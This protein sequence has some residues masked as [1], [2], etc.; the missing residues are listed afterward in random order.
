MTH[1]KICGLR[2]PEH[3]IAAV[4]AGADMLGFIFYP[5]A[6]RYVDPSLA[7][8]I[9]DAV[10]RRAQ[11]VGVFVNETPERIAEVAD[12]VGLDLVQLSGDEPAELTAAVGRPVARTVHVDADT[13]LEQVAD[14]AAGARYIH[15]DA[16]QRGQ[17]GGTGTRFDW[18]FARE[19]SVLGP[20]LLAGG[21]D[22]E[23]VADA[24]A[25]AAPWGVDVSSG[26]E[27][28]GAKDP[29]RIYSFVKAAKT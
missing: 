28:D 14:R 2:Q 20:V 3:A 10:G 8:E 12:L 21:L 17:Y 18:T 11:L 16:R 27:S 5:P 25:A 29:R 19:A 9:A 23:N 24:I 13:T 15:L 7:R 1:V 26:V 22:P 6:R 4:E